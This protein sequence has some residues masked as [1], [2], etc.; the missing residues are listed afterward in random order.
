MY[1]GDGRG[2]QAVE[3]RR[4]RPVARRTSVDETGAVGA[5]TKKIP[6]CGGTA[7]GVI[8][9][10]GR[11]ARAARRAVPAPARPA[12]TRR[13][14]GSGRG[15]RDSPSRLRMSAKGVRAG[16]E[17][18]RARVHAAPRQPV[19]RR[20]PCTT[21]PSSSIFEVRDATARRRPATA[22]AAIAKRCAAEALRR[23]RDAAARAPGT[24]QTRSRPS[25][26]GRRARRRDGRG[27]SGSNV[28]PNRPVLHADV[29]VCRSR[30]DFAPHG[31]EQ[32]RHALAGHRRD[33]IERHL[34]LLQVLLQPLRAAPDRRARRSCSPRRCAASSRSDHGVSSPAPA[35][36]SSSRADDLEVLDRIAAG[37]RRHVDDVHEH[38][39]ALEVREELRAEAVA[40]VRAFDQAGHVGHDERAVVAQLDDAEIRASAS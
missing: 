13:R 5:S 23:A 33:R 4:R 20:R 6:G 39:R 31:F 35:N 27:E 36:S 11:Q 2:H 19:E 8:D 29:G 12:A 28:P 1:V 17:E 24:S 9:H 15:P 22:S 3:R 7:H 10:R 38:L 14:N 34:P 37:R 40:V 30:D 26:R 18:Q 21:G 25:A 16:D 32:L